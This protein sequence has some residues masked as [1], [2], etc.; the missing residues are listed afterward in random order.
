MKNIDTFHIEYTEKDVA[1]VT[2]ENILCRSTD[3]GKTWETHWKAPE[4]ILMISCRS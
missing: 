1:W 2:D 4:E 3:R